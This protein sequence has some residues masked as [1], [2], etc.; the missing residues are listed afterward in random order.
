MGPLTTAQ[1]ETIQQKKKYK[2]NI[3][4]FSKALMMLDV[5]YT[6]GTVKNI[7]HLKGELLCI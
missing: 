4:Q 5:S 3:I 2:T 7:I 1:S 6:A